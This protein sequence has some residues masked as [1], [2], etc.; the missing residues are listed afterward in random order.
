MT[1]FNEVIKSES[2]T[3]C[4]Y[5][6]QQNY[7]LSNLTLLTWWGMQSS[8]FSQMWNESKITNS[9][10]YVFHSFVLSML[11][12]IAFLWC[13]SLYY[14]VLIINIFNNSKEIS[15]LKSRHVTLNN[16]N[17]LSEILKVRNQTWVLLGSKPSVSGSA[18]LC[19]YHTS[20][21]TFM[22]ALDQGS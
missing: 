3:S 4:K 12:I 6:Y 17:V 22:H 1:L 11:F 5:I 7:F 15:I 18:S 19:L 13:I 2:A 16:T 14:F 20:S 21:V 8:N 9:V 10:H